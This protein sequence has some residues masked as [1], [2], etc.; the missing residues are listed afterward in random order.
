MYFLFWYSLEDPNVKY[1]AELSDTVVTKNIAEEL[2][3]GYFH[4]SFI[5]FFNVE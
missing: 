3:N 5:Q 1:K 2:Q 4:K